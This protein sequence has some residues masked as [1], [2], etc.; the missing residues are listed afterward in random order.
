MNENEVLAKWIWGLLP[1]QFLPSGRRVSDLNFRRDHEFAGALLDK[2]ER[3]YFY[4]IDNHKGTGRARDVRAAQ[5]VADILD[6]KTH[7]SVAIGC[8]DTWRDAVVDAALEVIRREAA[9]EGG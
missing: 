5:V 9:K 3:E 8:G 7:E 4:L 1:L 2:L 6:C